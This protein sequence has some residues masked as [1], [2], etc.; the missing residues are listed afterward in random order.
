[1][2]KFYVYC[3]FRPWNAEPCYIGKGTGKR[4]FYH[5]RVGARHQNKHLGAILKKAKKELPCV[6]LHDNL[7]EK[8][9]LEYEIALIKAI[10]RKAYG[11]PLVNQTDGG[12]GLSGYRHSPRVKETLRVKALGNKAAV[13]GIKD[14]ELKKNHLV[15]ISTKAKQRWQEPK[16]RQL[17]VN[18]LAE[19]RALNWRDPKQ[20]QQ[21]S[22]KLKALWKDP[23]FLAKR[24]QRRDNAK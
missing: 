23:E 13:G 10:G 19:A 8:Q 14:P 3:L 20:R 11:G 21:A 2:N 15:K 18:R 9:A 6:I 7:T 1:M 22:I 24:K 12:D 16:Y 5:Q 17:A 4:A